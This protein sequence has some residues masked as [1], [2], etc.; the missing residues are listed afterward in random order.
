MNIIHQ[1]SKPEQWNFV[2]TE[3]NPADIGT[4]S[5]K[6]ALIDPDSDKE[7]KYV[8]K[9]T[10]VEQFNANRFVKFSTWNKLICAFRLQRR[11]CFQIKDKNVTFLPESVEETCKTELFV[12]RS[13]QRLPFKE[14]IECLHDCKSLPRKS[15]LLQLNPLPNKDGILCVGGRLS[16]SPF[17]ADQRH[18][19]IIDRKSHI[20]VLLVRRFHENVKHH[21][22]VFTEGAIRSH[23]FWIKGVKRILTL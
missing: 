23:G 8:V 17:S 11:V 6:C 18:P 13:S 7:I 16:Q 21:G 12:L 15:A 10:S 19:I 2:L 5:V 22:R 9:K 3:N 14:K 20:A 1:R 4:R